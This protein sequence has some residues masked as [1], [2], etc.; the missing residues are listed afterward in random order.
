MPLNSPRQKLGTP[1]ELVEA[2]SKTAD[3]DLRKEISQDR[4]L[5]CSTSHGTPNRP[6][7]NNTENYL[8]IINNIVGYR[9]EFFDISKYRSFDTSYRMCFAPHPL[10][11]PRTFYADAERCCRHLEYRYR[12]D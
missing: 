12:I 9:I 3:R 11:H 4:L 6:Q 10:W 5:L 8:L 1:F 2:D 7:P